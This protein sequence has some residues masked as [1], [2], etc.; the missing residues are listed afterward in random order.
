MGFSK[1]EAE[2]KMGKQVRTR[3]RYNAH[4]PEGTTGIVIGAR[5]VHSSTGPDN[6]DFD[7]YK[8]YIWWDRPTPR[9]DTMG[10]TEYEELLTEL[11]ETTLADTHALRRELE[12]IGPL[13]VF[14]QQIKEL[15]ERHTL[16]LTRLLRCPKP[17]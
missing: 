14:E 17:R 9:V 1:E 13:I 8:V 3:V 10:K 5:F 7:Y 11:E 6:K 15:V 12:S 4:V 2:A 16:L